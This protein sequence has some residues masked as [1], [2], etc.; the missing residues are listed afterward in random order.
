MQGIN[1]SITAVLKEFIWKREPHILLSSFMTKLN[2]HLPG[3]LQFWSDY[4]LYQHIHD[5]FSVRCTYEQEGL[6]LSIPHELIVELFDSEYVTHAS[7][8][9]QAVLATALLQGFR[10]NLD[11]MSIQET[12]EIFNDSADGDQIGFYSLTSFTQFVNTQSE[13]TVNKKTLKGRYIPL[14]R[15]AD[16]FV[17]RQLGIDPTP[18]ASLYFNTFAL[19]VMASQAL[20]TF[21][22]PIF[23]RCAQFE[24]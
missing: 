19:R 3:H 18:D 17:F 22:D 20:P 12:F 9:R 6:A 8:E 2:G 5:H 1:Q 4:Q 10:A 15:N 13:L 14:D 23:H 11:R 7:T 24:G 21:G 16:M